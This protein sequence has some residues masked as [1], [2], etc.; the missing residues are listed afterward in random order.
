MLISYH[1]L[2]KFTP[3]KATPKEVADKITLN[4]V[5]VDSLTK[6]GKDTIFEI[7]N[8]GITNRPDC[9]SHLGIAREVAAYFKLPLNDP[10]EDLAK[11]KLSPKKTIPLRVK[12]NNP[13]PCPRYCALVLTDIKVGP[14]PKWLKVGVE[15]CGVRSINNVVDVTNYVMLESGQPLHAF[16]YEEVEGGKIIV[17]KAK[18]GEQ[19]ITLDGVKRALNQDV[20]VIADSQK[21][22]GVAGII[23]G[24]NTEV[25]K[26]TKTIILESANFD[27]TNNR[28]SSKFLKLRT[29]ASTRF[30]KG[31][32][33]NLPYPALIR[34]VELLQEAA[35]ARIASET[36]DLQSKT[37]KPWRVQVQ[38]SWI[39]KFLG[40]EL[41][42]KQIKAILERLQLKTEL[43]N[44]FLSVTVPTFRPD[45]KMEADLAEEVARIYGYNKIP[46]TLPKGEMK[47]SPPNRAIFWR[48]RIKTFL[49]HLGFTEVYTYPLIGQELIG[50]VRGKIK[51]HLKLINPLTVDREYFRL[52]LIPSLFE[53]LKKNLSEFENIRI[54]ELGRVYVP[55]KE[56][57]PPQEK[58][59]LAGTI[60][61]PDKFYELKGV[62]EVL[63]GEMG[64]KSCHFQLPDLKPNHNLFHPERWASVQSKTTTIGQVGEI[65]PQALERFGI[66]K[67]ITVFDLDFDQLVKLAT[68]QKN[69]QPLLKYPPV[70]EDL[71]FRVKPQVLTGDLTAAIKNV[72][73]LIRQADFIDAYQNSQTFRLTYQDSHRTLTEKEAGT[74]RN[75]VK[76]HLKK[77]FGV[78]IKEK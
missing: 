36:F 19:I 40:T 22:I 10:R 50:K 8:K 27:P 21:P 2:K 55:T 37:V 24:Q 44:G 54:F 47:P 33:V 67:K 28:L 68:T 12:I 4:L 43:K 58:L 73:P 31:Q 35:G 16:D 23:G 20:L 64:I 34:A 5:E 29:E 13:D 6:R 41:P 3:L 1:W 60:T 70:I 65:H 7:E 72:D 78:V 63:L 39:N 52:S 61:G 26:R 9:F 59:R 48:R 45:L 25:T 17:R 11:R 30:E 53:V 76:K 18:N 56:G 38:P 66:K 49:A 15:N 62:V 51:D 14:S 71:T 42:A 77:T 57:K 75:K 46:I 32:D 74:V 69:Y